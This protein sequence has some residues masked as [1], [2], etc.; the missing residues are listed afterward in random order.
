MN[1]P[2]LTVE[3]DEWLEDVSEKMLRAKVSSFAVM[4]EQR[5]LGVVTQTDLLHQAHSDSDQGLRTL[6]TFPKKKVEEVMSTELFTIHPGQSMERAA[7]LMVEHRCHRLYVVQGERP[8][9]VLSTRD[10]MLAIRDR[11][12]ERPIHEFMSSPVYSVR[13][14]QPVVEAG[15]QLEEKQVTGIVVT[16]GRWPVGVFTQAAALE[17]RHLPPQTPV[18]QVMSSAI[19][20]LDQDT[21]LFRAAAQAAAMEVRRVIVCQQSDPVGV[22]SGLDFARVVSGAAPRAEHQ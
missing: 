6:F 20:T 4:H 1:Q 13:A 5:M 16:D 22:L 9:G 3:R 17:A 11:R 8:V 2:V 12:I 18:E 21:P 14:H 15:R 10:I 7:A 19:L